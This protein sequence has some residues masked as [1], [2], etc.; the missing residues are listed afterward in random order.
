LT[1][2]AVVYTGLLISFV[3]VLT[4]LALKDADGDGKSIRTRP[5]PVLSLV[6]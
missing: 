5:I 6:S 1:A 3:V 4:Q 2:Y